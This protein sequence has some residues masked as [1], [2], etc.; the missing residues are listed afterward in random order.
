[1]VALVEKLATS[2]TVP[3]TA[4]LRLLPSLPASMELCARLEGAGAS[5][6]ALHGRTKEQNKQVCARAL[7]PT[8]RIACTAHRVH[9]APRTARTAHRAHRAPRAP[10]APR[11]AHRAH[12]AP[13]A[14]HWSCSARAHSLAGT[15]GAA[16]RP[17]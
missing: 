6:I 3:V 4:K 11:T 13:H 16:R 2:L 17:R 7:H 5:V 14:C 8:P 15:R 12:R 10:R 9:R 1:M